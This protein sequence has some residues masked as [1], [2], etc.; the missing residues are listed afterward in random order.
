MRI[1]AILALILLASV[2]ELSSQ[3]RPQP[4]LWTESTS[5]GVALRWVFSP[6]NPFPSE[7]YTVLRK[8]HGSLVQFQ[9]IATIK[10]TLNDSLLTANERDTL[11]A[12]YKKIT[13]ANS[14]PAERVSLALTLRL[15][16]YSRPKAY[17][18]AF[19][20]QYLDSAARKNSLYDYAVAIG[21]EQLATIQNITLQTPTLLA[22]P[23]KVVAKSINSGAHLGWNIQGMETRGVAG[24]NV[25]RRV[26][27]SGNFTAVKR[28]VLALFFDEDFPADFLFEDD[29]LTNG[30]AYEYAVTSVNIFGQESE[31]SASVPLTP[32]NIRPLAPPIAVQALAQADSVLL[33]WLPSGDRR[34]KGLNVYRSLPRKAG[35]K[36]TETP[37]P[38]RAKSY[39]DRPKNI[40]A[41]IVGYSLTALDS[42]GNE[43]DKS[44]EHTIPVPDIQAPDVPQFFIAQGERGRILLAWSRSQAMDIQ[45]YELERSTSTNGTY[46]LISKVLQDSNFVDSLSPSAGKTA[47]WYRLR[48]VDLRG[49]RSA[50]TAPTLGKIPDIIAPPAPAI[51]SIRNGDGVI[52]LEWQ[53]SYDKDLMGYWINRTDDT[54]YTP[55][56]LN[57][58]LLPPTSA[59]F[60]DT[61]A[62]PGV[63]YFYEVVSM[64]SAMN[65]S[66]P[67]AR[68]AG[69]S[70]DTRHPVSPQIDSL[71]VSASGVVV[72]WSWGGKPQTTFEL[73]VER[74]RDGKRFVQIS[75]LIDTAT[76]RFSDLS[77]RDNDTYYYRLRI[78]NQYG[79][80]SDPSNVKMCRLDR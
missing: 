2:S 16:L 49:N 22:P 10:P 75:P 30:I 50:W 55:V 45:G 48:S 39:T 37:L 27:N 41:L 54:L 47:F 15:M 1:A 28:P 53:A 58:E 66:T 78:R 76:S 57:T 71:I 8:K 42:A 17:F 46:T 14:T 35:V 25:Y 5:A 63:L 69:K 59:A 64:D 79:T 26:G 51:S 52:T 4:R 74:S 3:T 65:Y 38:F 20:L 68:I 18:P 23:E 67:S 73:A 80:W 6:E 24:W 12:L 62:Q 29:S 43:S 36:I 60:H 13:S 21:N 77:A 70:Y 40:P 72:T 33:S 61:S 9:P 7:G 31:K 19:G 44:F 56:T 32:T 34:V 11:Q